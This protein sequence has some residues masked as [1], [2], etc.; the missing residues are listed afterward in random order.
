VGEE[1]DV[2][3]WKPPERLD[4]VIVTLAIA[5][6]TVS[7]LRRYGRV[8]NIVYWSGTS[9][10][11]SGTVHRVIE[12]N[13]ERGR[14]YVHV[15]PI[16]VSRVVNDVYE[17]G[18]FLIA[19]LHTHPNDEDHSDVDDCGTISKREGFIS[20]ILP[21]Y[22]RFTISAIPNWFGYELHRGAWAPFD[23]RRIRL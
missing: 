15:D 8:E 1:N 21:F 12:P 3:L 20:L 11:A 18:E 5:L 6:E 16:E 7:S 2:S 9:N 10:E 22:A 4:T 23:V 17:H 19:Q 14:R 13:A